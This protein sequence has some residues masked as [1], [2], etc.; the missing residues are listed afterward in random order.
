MMVLSHSMIGAGIGYQL[1]QPVVA[2]LLMSLFH[3]VMDKVPHFWPK[4]KK[5]GKLFALSDIASCGLL[6][7]FILVYQPEHYVSVF[8]GAFGGILVDVIFVG[9]PSVRR[10]KYGQ[11]QHNRQPHLSNPAY[12]LTDLMAIILGLIIWYI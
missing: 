4:S 7:L 12:L 3:L 8:A 5:W 1:D 10:S 11:W 2:F 9:I 6:L